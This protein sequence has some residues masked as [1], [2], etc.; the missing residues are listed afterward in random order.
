MLQNIASIFF[1]TILILPIMMDAEFSEEN[2]DSH[3][4]LKGSHT[5]STER[6]KFWGGRCVIDVQCKMVSIGNTTFQIS[7]CQNSWNLGELEG[8]CEPSALIWIIVAFI[9]MLLLLRFC[10]TLLHC[11]HQ[12]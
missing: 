3:S 6:N 1:S 10:I 7:V 12:K 8:R 11:C 9:A 2:V 5:K 4:L